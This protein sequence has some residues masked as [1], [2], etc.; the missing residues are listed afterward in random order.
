MSMLGLVSRSVLCIPRP[1]GPTLTGAN[2]TR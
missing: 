1:N 2:R